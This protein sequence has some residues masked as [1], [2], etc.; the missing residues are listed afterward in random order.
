ML[1]LPD[2][3][4]NIGVA[5]TFDQWH[6]QKHEPIVGYATFGQSA[7]AD[8]ASATSFNWW[9]RLRGRGLSRLQPGFSIWVFN[10]PLI[11]V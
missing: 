9:F 10:R 4:L 11:K 7:L 8:S 1:D 6:I 5:N 3:D 2:P